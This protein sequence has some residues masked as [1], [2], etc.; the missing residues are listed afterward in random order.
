MQGKEE[1]IQKLI[2]WQ[3]FQA[4]LQDLLNRI[5]AEREKRGGRVYGH[6]C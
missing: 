1:E 6:F 3:V 5:K 2:Q 4:D